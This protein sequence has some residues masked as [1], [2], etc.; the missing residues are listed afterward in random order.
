MFIWGKCIFENARPVVRQ[1]ISAER[2]LDQ[3]T[4]QWA[5]LSLASEVPPWKPSPTSS[6]Q[7]V[8]NNVIPLGESRRLAIPSKSAHCCNGVQN[9]LWGMRM[10]SEGTKNICGG[11]QKVLQRKAMFS[12]R[13]KAWKYFCSLLYFFHHL[14]PKS[15][16]TVCDNFVDKNDLL[17]KIIVTVEF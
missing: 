1:C 9:N 5:M 14:S 10:F 15:G 7:I 13:A 17:I 3:E 4:L 8:S 2:N 12:G 6:V 11:T 16:L